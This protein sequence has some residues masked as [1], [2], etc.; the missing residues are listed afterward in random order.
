MILTTIIPNTIHIAILERFLAWENKNPNPMRYGAVCIM[1]GSI[2][3][4]ETTKNR[5]IIVHKNLI[6]GAILVF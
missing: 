1:R 4:H 2:V 6:M 5:L 3:S